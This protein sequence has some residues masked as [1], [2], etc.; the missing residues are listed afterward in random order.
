MWSRGQTRGR[1]LGRVCVDS[2]DGRVEMWSC[3][4]TGGRVGV[5]SCASSVGPVH[6]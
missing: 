5:M 3:G 4:Q 1:G 6:V 2:V